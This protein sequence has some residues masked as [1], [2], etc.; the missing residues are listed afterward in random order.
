MKS[1]GNK[2]IEIIR[3]FHFLRRDWEKMSMLINT[4]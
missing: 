1:A 3:Q 4:I 2:M